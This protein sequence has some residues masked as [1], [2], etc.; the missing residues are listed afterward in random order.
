MRQLINNWSIP[1]MWAIFWGYWGLA[2]SNAQ[3]TARAEST[4]ARLLHLALVLVAFSLVSFVQIGPLRWRIWPAQTNIIQLGVL[5]TFVGLGFAV[6]ARLHLGTNWSGT[7][8]IKTDHQL[9]RSGPYALVRHPIYTG[10]LL[11]MAGTTIAVGEIRG[12]IAIALLVAAYAHKLQ[13][14]ETW[15]VQQFGTAYQQ[16]QHEVRALIPFAW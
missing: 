6:W 11:A 5:L 1:I 8:T 2:A 12:V 15:L 13:M 14:E 16:Y 10:V 3:K 7:I 4:A 9:I